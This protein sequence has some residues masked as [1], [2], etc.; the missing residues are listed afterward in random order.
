MSSWEQSELSFHE[1]IRFLVGGVDAGHVED[2]L[3][4]ETKQEVL[5]R[6]TGARPCLLYFTGETF[7]KELVYKENLL[8]R[9]SSPLTSK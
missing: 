7:S 1:V 2:G 5:M 8:S 9:V 6:I 4:K 3:R